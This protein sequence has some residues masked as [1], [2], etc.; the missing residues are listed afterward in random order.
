MIHFFQ[1]G[2]RRLNIFGQWKMEYRFL[3]LG[4]GVLRFCACSELER[5]LAVVLRVM[6]LGL[7]LSVQI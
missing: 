1:T 5:L 2:F 4:N 7:F 3:Q 6:L